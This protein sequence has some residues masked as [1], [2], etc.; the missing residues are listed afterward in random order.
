[1]QPGK[2]LVDVVV[3]HTDVLDVLDVLD[4]A[5]FAY[6][7]GERRLLLLVAG[8]HEVRRLEPTRRSLL[9]MRKRDDLEK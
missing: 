6:R 1:M 7:E 5:D 4:V 8:L 3:L 2:T 9:E